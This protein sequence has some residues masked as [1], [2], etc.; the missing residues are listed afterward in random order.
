[1]LI[2]GVHIAN[3]AV[4]LAG[5]RV[6]KDVPS[7]AIVG[8]VPA[9]IIGYRYDEETISNLLQTQWWNNTEEW[10]KENWKMQTDIDKQKA[11]YNN[12]M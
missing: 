3:G 10:F 7:Y 9:K 2:G 5:A 12:K 11:Y 1:M 6:T 4:E 8:G